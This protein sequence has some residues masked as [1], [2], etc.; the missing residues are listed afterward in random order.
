MPEV[1]IA[2]HGGQLADVKAPP[3]ADAADG[4]RVPA[5]DAVAEYFLDP[6]AVRFLHRFAAGAFDDFAL[7]VFARDD[8]AGLAAYQ[9]A[10]ELRRQ[11]RVRSQGPRLYL[12]NMLHTDSAPAETFNLTEYARLQVCLRDVLGGEADAQSLKDA[13]ARE[14]LRRA[15]LARLPQHGSDAFMARNAGRW[16]APD[17][18][19]A[20]L[21]DLPD[22]GEG[23]RIV[24]VGT[25]CD[26]P[27]M[28]EI[29]AG[30][31]QVMADLQEY[32]RVPAPSEETTPTAILRGLSC[33]PLHIRAAPPAR[34]TSALHAE[35][36]GAD[37]VIASVDPNDDG[38]GWE[39][40]GLRT[41]VEAN[42]G[43]FLDLGFRPFRPDAAWRANAR[44][45]IEEALA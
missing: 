6:F 35:A 8:V 39:V 41:A 44:R 43:R 9:Y 34:F 42:G 31:G 12:W 37:L 45:R 36:A 26:I 7:I 21:A 23:P 30:L 20:L 29:C 3:L 19:A 28:H 25:A 10:L 27:V 11:G 22:S 1:L 13:I 17:T 24:L 40:P 32:G 38:F 33:D 14:A 15:A 4:P 18:H 16:M 5:V 2:A